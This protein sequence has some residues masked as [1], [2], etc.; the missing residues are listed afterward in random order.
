MGHVF[1]ITSPGK[2]HPD[3]V[4]RDVR[5]IVELGKTVGCKPRYEI[6]FEGEPHKAISDALH[7][8]KYVSAI[9]QRLTEH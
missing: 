2:V 6:P 7:Q 9:W 1:A 5:T 8:V 4:N 3:T